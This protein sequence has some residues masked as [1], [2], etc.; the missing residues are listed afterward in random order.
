MSLKR[1]VD[2]RDAD[3]AMRARALEA[4]AE[5]AAER[6]DRFTS[7]YVSL[8]PTVARWAARL[9]GPGTEVEDVVQEVFM[10]A[11]GARAQF[12]GDSKPSTW[13]F[14]ITRNVVRARRRRERLRRLL[15]FGAPP[16]RTD[17]PTGPTP[18]E[19]LE[20]REAG[21]VLY[22]ALEAL[23][24]KQR[25]AFVL[26]ELEGLA[27]AEIAELLGINHST[28]RVLLFRARARIEDRLRAMGIVREGSA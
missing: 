11:H 26:Y 19:E 13:L 22:T 8:A 2:V 21:R 25:T 28:L 1:R 20:R 10:I 14:G 9:G 18:A 12:R 5:A 7:L 23:P 16:E 6:E 3:D 27:G 24:D 17:V 4:P 15:P